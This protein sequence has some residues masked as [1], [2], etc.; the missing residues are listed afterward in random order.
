M[1]KFC[2]ETGVGLVPWGP[3]SFGRLARPASVTKGGE[4]AR[5]KVSYIS[6]VSNQDDEIISRVEELARKRYWPMSHVALAWINKRVSSPI[7]GFSKVERLYE[8]LAARGKLLSDAEERYL[9]EPY[10]PLPIVG[11]S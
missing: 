2:N 5:S 3:L 7:V 11:H 4:T 6:N 10:K 1:N 9:D 8:A